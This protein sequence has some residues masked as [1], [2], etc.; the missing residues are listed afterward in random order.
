MMSQLIPSRVLLRK[1]VSIVSLLKLGTK[2]FM[3]MTKLMER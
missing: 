2:I 1:L 3:V